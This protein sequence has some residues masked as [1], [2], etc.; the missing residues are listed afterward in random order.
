MM[1]GAKGYSAIAEWGRNHG[2]EIS[3]F[4]GPCSHLLRKCS[5]KTTDVGHGRIEERFLK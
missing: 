5:D 2:K 4:D 1:C 3:T